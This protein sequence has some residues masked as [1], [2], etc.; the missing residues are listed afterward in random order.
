MKL[1][2]QDDGVSSPDYTCY[3]YELLGRLHKYTSPTT[4]E[5]EMYEAGWEACI[6][7][8]WDAFKT[9]SLNITKNKLELAAEELHW[10]RLELEESYNKAS[11]SIVLH[12]HECS[13]GSSC[14]ACRV[15]AGIARARELLAEVINSTQ[16]IQK[17]TNGL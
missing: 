10:A 16:T 2:I 1:P 9:S 4:F 3:D 6:R 15:L 14:D 12:H 7:F 8:Y 17:G 13:Y 11:N 5:Q